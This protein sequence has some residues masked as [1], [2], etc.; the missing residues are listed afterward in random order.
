MATTSSAIGWTH[1]FDPALTRARA[2]QPGDRGNLGQCLRGRLR[3]KCADHGKPARERLHVGIAW[4][5]LVC[6]IAR[7]L[8]G[9]FFQ[10][11]VHMGL[12]QRGALRCISVRH[13]NMII[14]FDR[15]RSRFLE[16]IHYT[17]CCSYCEHRC[18]CFADRRITAAGAR[19]TIDVEAG[20]GNAVSNRIRLVA[21][22]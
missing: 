9:R 4:L 18:L 3:R 2:S 12:E 15:P 7:P 22:V 1:D 8:L 13:S 21:E 20:H 5:E 11:P 14:L 17:N 19:Q 10:T 16:F 6:C